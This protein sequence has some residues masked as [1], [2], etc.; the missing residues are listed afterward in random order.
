MPAGKTY[1]MEGP[2]GDPGVNLRALRELFKLADERSEELTHTFSASVL[3]IY[4]EQIY[5]LLSGSKEQ[6]DKLDVKQG[7]EGMFV[8]GLRV[9]EVRSMDDVAM[10]IG[11]GKSNRS[12]FATNMNEHSSRS[13]L[14]LSLYV[15]SSHLTRGT[16]MRG[17]LHLIDLAGSERLSR[18]GAQVGQQLC[19][20]VRHALRSAHMVFF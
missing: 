1:T 7:P 17:K 10:L 8:P 18:T 5:D 14:V 16:T 12:T 15:M 9:E 2:E 6:D 3:E 4:N 11:R 19:A 20:S 13:H